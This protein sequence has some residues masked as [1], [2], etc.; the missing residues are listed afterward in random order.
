MSWVAVG[1]AVAQ[2][3]YGIYQNVQGSKLAKEAER[4][5]PDYRIPDAMK[6]AMMSAELRSLQGLPEEVKSQMRHEMDRSRMASLSQINERRGGLG[7]IAQLEQQ[8]QDAIRK[9]GVMDAEQREKNLMNLQN[10]RMQMSQ[11]EQQAWEWNERQKYEEQ[12][13][14]G[15]ALKGAGAQNIAGGITTAGSVAASGALSKQ[16]P[17][18]DAGLDVGSNNASGLSAQNYGFNPTTN[19]IEYKGPRHGLDVGATS[20]QTPTT[21]NILSDIQSSD[22]SN[23]DISSP[24]VSSTSTSPPLKNYGFNPTTGEIE[25]QGPQ[26][27]LGAVNISGGTGLNPVEEIY[28]T[29]IEQTSSPSVPPLSF[30]GDI[31]TP[32]DYNVYKQEYIKQHASIYPGTL[33]SYTVPDE[34]SIQAAYNQQYGVNPIIQNP[35]VDLSQF[36]KASPE[37]TSSNVNILGPVG[38]QGESSVTTSMSGVPVTLI[39]DLGGRVEGVTGVEGGFDFGELDPN[40]SYA[41]EYIDP[42]TLNTVIEPIGGV[43]TD[44]NIS[45]SGELTQFES[46]DISSMYAE[47]TGAPSIVSPLIASGVFEGN[48]PVQ[49]LAYN[50][51][52]NLYEP[53]DGYVSESSGATWDANVREWVGSVESKTEGG[54]SI[55]SDDGTTIKL[56]NTGNIDYEAMN[57]EESEYSEGPLYYHADGTPFESENLDVFKAIGKN[58]GKDKGLHVLFDV[59]GRP[60][61]PDKDGL[62]LSAEDSKLRL[63]YFSLPKIEQQKIFYRNAGNLDKYFKEKKMEMEKS[64]MEGNMSLYKQNMHAIKNYNKPVNLLSPFETHITLLGINSNSKLAIAMQNSKEYQRLH[65]GSKTPDVNLDILTATEFPLQ[66]KLT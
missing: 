28:P 36:T 54:P 23:I 1:L 37:L 32:Q 7:A 34:A 16:K 48:I 35:S 62:P 65:M 2:V 9:Q 14:K 11:Q 64:S 3:G 55:I 46:S 31:S 30:G 42:N 47:Y 21:Q 5:R 56:D 60:I 4:N 27:G 50:E 12:L 51:D 57:I 33:E 66:N 24:S 6:S 40:R 26:Y 10:M 38:A 25:Y 41:I 19:Q 13:A 61:L 15:L 29:Q 39:D 52:L 53:R 18:T 8:Q 63:D 59:N 58:R 44:I 45:P 49:D 43:S 20:L 17:P 22:I